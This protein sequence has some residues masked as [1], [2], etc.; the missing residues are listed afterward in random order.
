[1]APPAEISIPTTSLTSDPNNSNKPYTLY[2]ITLRLP[3]RSFVVQKRYSDFLA[4]HNQLTSNVGSP[5]PAPLPSKTWFKS[6]VSSPELTEKRRQGLEAYLRA[7]AEPPDRRWRDTSAWRAFLNLPGGAG[8]ATTSTASAS[9][10]SVDLHKKIPAIGLR[11]A[12][13]A[14]ASD[15]GTWLDLHREMKGALHEARVALG[16]RDAATDNSVKIESGSAAKRAL[17]KAGAL[18]VAL[19]DGLQVLKDGGRV[20]EGELRRRRDLLAAA[21]VE[22]DGLDKLSSSLQGGN[23]YNHQGGDGGVGGQGRYAGAGAASTSSTVGGSSIG[24]GFS[25]FGSGGRGRVLGAP[26]PETDKTRE[27]DNEGV[28]QLQRNTLKEQE[29]DMDVLAKIVRRQKEMG[30]AIDDEIGRHIDMLDRMNDDADV[31]GKKLGVAKERDEEEEDDLSESGDGGSTCASACSAAASAEE[32]EEKIHEGE[33]DH[34]HHK[35]QEDGDKEGEVERP[36][37]GGGGSDGGD[38]GGNVVDG[39]LLLVVRFVL[40]GVQ[41]FVVLQWVL[42]KFSEGLAWVVELGMLLLGQPPAEFRPA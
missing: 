7:I 17:I 21:R 24:G 16:R 32:L 11:D 30:L 10:M 37:G 35:Q 9:G 31:L 33:E 1:M 41:G 6:T 23:Q 40:A 12:N 3:L 18:L 20:G 14:A 2:N 13:L 27:L 34:H 8:G 26:L 28:L 19:G 29:Q 42:G 38:D 4:L 39:V 5:P 25:R 22:R 36:E 15:P